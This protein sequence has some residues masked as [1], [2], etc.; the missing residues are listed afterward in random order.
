MLKKV[1]KTEPTL[2]VLILTSEFPNIYEP[3]CGMFVKEQAHYLKRVCDVKVLSP[4]SFLSRYYFW[5]RNAFKEKIPYRETTYGI[6]VF[7]P[8]FYYLPKILRPLNGLF[9]F[10]SVLPAIFKI[11]RLYKFDLIYAINAFPDGFAAA[12]LGK[13]LNVPVVIQTIGT[14]I[15][16]YTGFYFR[17][18]AILWSLN[19]C[20]HIISVSKAMK[21]RLVDHG[22]DEGKIQVNYNGIDRTLFFY[23]ESSKKKD[24][25]KILLFVGNLKKEKGVFELL[26][27]IRSVK[28]PD[29]KVIIIG[30][31]PIRSDIE[32]FVKKAGIDDKVSLLGAKLHNEVATWMKISDLLCLPSYN[33]GL[34]NVILEALSCGTP[35]VATN[36][37]GIPE[38]LASEDYGYMVPP[39][40]IKE[41]S[42]KINEALY[43]QWDHGKI[44]AHVERFGW[45][46]HAGLLHSLFLN[47]LAEKTFENENLKKNY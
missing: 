32:D 5:S 17:R 27:A 44:S 34:P 10:F 21:Q 22:I 35:V 37:G 30:D 39:Q 38:V 47:L 31:G 25:K 4:I 12:V 2:K 14:D 19:Y 26:E 45:M 40:N 23:D 42:D 15:N 24:G 7:R 46:E 41:L 33:E 11:R 36:V 9:Y 8:T 29:V 43:R 28:F 3:Y 1:L 16:V 13:L 20:D 6:D 18:K